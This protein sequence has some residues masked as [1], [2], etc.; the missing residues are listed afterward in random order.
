MSFGNS[1]EDRE[2]I[3]GI[4]FFTTDKGEGI[5]NYPKKHYVFGVDKNERTNNYYKSTIR[6]FKN[7][8][9]QLIKQK[10]LQKSSFILFYRE[11]II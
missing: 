1:E 3:P 9:K 6:I 7:I 11:F 5:I 2:Y 4:K 8:K 10:E